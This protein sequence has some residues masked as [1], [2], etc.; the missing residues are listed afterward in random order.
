[1]QPSVIETCDTID[2]IPAALHLLGAT[3]ICVM[4]AA[5]VS[6]TPVLA[7]VSG[8]LPSIC[9]DLAGVP[10]LGRRLGHVRRLLVA[11]Q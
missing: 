3:L 8:V 4:L 6:L 7:V 5:I 2:A 10:P 11:T 1:M 9:R